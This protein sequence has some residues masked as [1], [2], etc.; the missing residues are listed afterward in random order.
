MS[1]DCDVCR[2]NQIVYPRFD[3]PSAPSEVITA[4]VSRGAASI[5]A[6]VR[7][8]LSVAAGGILQ[9]G[10]RHNTAIAEF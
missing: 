1:C 2:V 3:S 7:L 4:M 9:Q 8:S 6:F 5:Y 10:G